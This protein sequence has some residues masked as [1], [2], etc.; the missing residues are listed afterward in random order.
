MTPP[1]PRRPGR[2]RVGRVV[3]V[4]VYL[5]ASWFVFAA[6]IVLSSAPRLVD[7]KSNV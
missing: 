7:R 1:E 3:G 6:F 2:L 5:S 4:P